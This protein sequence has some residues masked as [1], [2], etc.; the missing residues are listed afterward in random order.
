MPADQHAL[1]ARAAT[2]VARLD[3]ALG[4]QGEAR[5]LLERTLADLPDP[6]STAAASAG[7]GARHGSALHAASWRPCAQR[8]RAV[9]ELVQELG[10]PLLEAAAWAGIAHAEQNLR[11][12][13][14]SIEAAARSAAH[15]RLARRRRC[16]PLLE[17]FWW[18]ASA[19][20]VVERWDDCLRHADRGIRLARTYGVSFVFVAL[21][22]IRWR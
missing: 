16:A 10:E 1:R 8:A 11:D 14:A 21:T 19:E 15:P 20:D 12:I 7:T 9:L 2:F 4:R 22:H 17:T 6:R 18:L 13:P 3:Q 5:M